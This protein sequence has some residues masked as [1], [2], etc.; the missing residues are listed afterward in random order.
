MLSFFSPIL[1]LYFPTIFYLHYTSTFSYVSP[2]S[3]TFFPS[4][5]PIFIQ[6]SF[7][8]HTLPTP[9]G[10]GGAERGEGV[11]APGLGRANK[12]LRRHGTLATLL[13]SHTIISTFYFIFS[14]SFSLLLFFVWGICLGEIQ[15]RYFVSILV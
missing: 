5:P 12:R 6:T 8:P 11:A 15:L 4:F 2:P 10:G 14:F 3:P 1:F 13:G 9:W 7:V